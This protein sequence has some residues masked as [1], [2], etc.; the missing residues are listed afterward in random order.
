M[1][2]DTLSNVSV[3]HHFAVGLIIR[4]EIRHSSHLSFASHDRTV[5]PFRSDLTDERMSSA[6]PPPQMEA[7]D[8][9]PSPEPFKQPVQLSR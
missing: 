6:N 4:F 8:S 3:V 5:N 9:S 7:A 2:H 1:I